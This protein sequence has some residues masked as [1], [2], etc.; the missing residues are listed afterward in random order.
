MEE[1]E[2]EKEPIVDED[3]AYERYRDDWGDRLE[4]VLNDTYNMFVN[5]KKGYYKNADGKFVEHCISILTSI[6]KTHIEVLDKEKLREVKA[7]WVKKN[8]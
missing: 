4:E 2:T 8:D 1:F 6:T 7:I 5:A 3:A